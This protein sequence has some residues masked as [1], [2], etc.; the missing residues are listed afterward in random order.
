MN[1]RLIFYL[2]F[3]FLILVQSTNAQTKY[4]NSE[5]GYWLPNKGTLRVLVVFAEVLDDINYSTSSQSWKIA[6]L[7]DNPDLYFSQSKEFLNDGLISKYFANAS[8]NN[9][10][11]IGDYYPSLIQINK[12]DVAFNSV[13]TVMKKMNELGIKKSANG[14]HLYSK[15]KR[16]NSDFDSY[17]LKEFSTPKLQKAD[18]MLDMMIIVWRVNSKLSTTTNSGYCSVGP[19]NYS[20]KGYKGLNCYSEFVSNNNDAYVIMRHEFSHALY[21]G[22]NFHTAG[23]GAGLRCFIPAITGFS[24]LSS[25]DNIGQSY[26]AW[27]RW[28]MGWKNSNS[29]FLLSA[30]A[31]EEPRIIDPSSKTETLPFEIFNNV[32]TEK[33][34][35]QDS[36]IFYLRDFRSLGDAVRI[37]LPLIPNNNLKQSLWLEYHDEVSDD[38]IPNTNRKGIYAY[39]SIGK[40]D[41]KNIYNNSSSSPGNYLFFMPANGRWDF[42]YG[43]D[44]L[45]KKLYQKTID[46]LPNSLN[47]N[48]DLMRPLYD[49]NHNNK[50]T[51][52]DFILVEEVIKN[53]D[54]SILYPAF[55]MNNNISFCY[56][57]NRNITISSNPST[58]NVTTCIS[59]LNKKSPL[60]IDTVY[61]NGLNIEIIDSIIIKEKNNY[62]SALGV[63]ITWN[64]YIINNNVRWCGNIVAKP[65]DGKMEVLLKDSSSL[66]L[67][68]SYTPTQMNINEK[69]TID[70]EFLFSKPTVF[71]L[72]PNS[73]LHI[74]KGSS[75]VLRNDSTLYIKKGA[76]LII[77]EG[78]SLIILDTSSI[79]RVD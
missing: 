20:L 44:S 52:D 2:I 39:I 69:D 47:G 56:S 8:F 66:L 4:Q 54:T 18:S 24:N 14:Y 59:N 3:S 23:P 71:I 28:R 22:N 74:T 48:H 67:D 58:S 10:K 51:D 11:L 57:R 72:Y 64:N 45:T 12:E 65:N 63:K 40:D 46:S 9:Y 7:P 62:N 41:Y 5:N 34:K 26:N 50:L 35:Y 68:R 70:G 33:I 6:M 36:G 55:G 13:K 1:S 49:S 32:S 15:C 30:L 78:A 29:D 60:D 76:D 42:E 17:T 16:R 38:D 61:L 43:Y 27:D 53:N 19:A 77:D 31:L 73:S 25:W 21:G 37:E 75:L 79:I